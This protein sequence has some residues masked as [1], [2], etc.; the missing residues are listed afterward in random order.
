MNKKRKKALITGITGQDGSYLADFLLKKGYEVHGL[1]RRSSS[2]NTKRIDHL[3]K[4]RHEEDNNLFLHYGDLTDSS[5]ILRI[6]K[7]TNPDEIY[8]LGA[9]SHVAVSFESPEYTANCDALGPL[10]ILDAIKL[11]GLEKHTKFYQASTS[12]LYGLVRE[13]PQTEKTPFYPR[14][15]YAAAKLYAYW[16]TINYR[17]AYGIFA[18]NGILFNH[19]SPQRGET[20]VTRKITRGLAR[21][22]QGLDKFLY[23][24]NLDAKRDW[25]HA[26]DYV[27]MQWLMLQQDVP[28][29]YVIATGKMETVRRFVELSAKKIGWQKNKQGPSIIWEGNGV[30]EIGRRADTNQI[31]VK[32]DPK[33]FRPTEVELL[34]GDAT[35]A[36]EK[37]GWQYNISLEEL[38]SEMINHDLKEAKKDV[39]LKEKGYI[40]NNP[41][42]TIPNIMEK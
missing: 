20:F 16:I 18:C 29:D 30:N 11:L 3:Y 24:G 5:N 17:E 19:E 31:V 23:L 15:P 26:K 27:A 42:E 4:D 28:D 14:S 25:G 21:I 6:I 33:Y 41:L 22:D 32:I 39:L 10:R 35:K 36:K 13:I 7:E 1:K 9:Q 40:Q 12:E 8:N 38:I 34:L 2:F 37:L